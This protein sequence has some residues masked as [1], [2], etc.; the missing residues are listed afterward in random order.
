MDGAGLAGFCEGLGAG[1]L[2]LGM[3]ADVKAAPAGGAGIPR[4]VNAPPTLSTGLDTVTQLSSNSRNTALTCLYFA[5]IS[6]ECH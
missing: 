3:A 4:Q 1:A 2:G 6:H 5:E